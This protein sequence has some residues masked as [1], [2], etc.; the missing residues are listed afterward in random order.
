MAFDTR[1][2]E[3]HGTRSW[4]QYPSEAVIRFVARNYYS[5]DRSK[6]KI[7]DFGC[8]GGANTWYL[9]R[10][11]F[12]TYAFDGSSSAVKNA[13]QKLKNEGLKADF[14]VADGVEIDYGKAYFDCVID[15]CTIYSNTISNIKKMYANIFN[16]LKMGGKLLTIVFDINTTGYGTGKEIENNTF[17]DIA[18]GVLSGLGTQ[19]FYEREELTSILEDAGFKNIICEKYMR[20]DNGN[21]VSGYC[22]QADKIN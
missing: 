21:I 3:I 18:D 6:T 2:E 16:M 11:G 8:G 20:E 9:A 5:G 19:H 12:D 13:E 10:E 4:G 7:L 14:R 22:V 15:S 1:W 17:T